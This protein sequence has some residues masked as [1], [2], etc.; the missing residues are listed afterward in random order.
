[1]TD[2]EPAPTPST[3]ELLERLTDDTKRLVR[4]EIELAKAEM[5]TKAKATGI[6]AG[7]FGA[8]GILALFGLGATIATAII[9]LSLAVDAWLAA[10]IVTVVIF[11]AA[12]VAALVGKKRIS[13]GAP[14]MPERTV[15]SVK[16][17]INTVKGAGHD[18]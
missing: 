6:G 5:T 2:P 3:I 8:A 15:E 1:M 9:A 14:P 10:L 12:G 7:L 16:Q 18:G 11:V 17:D 4:D 13:E